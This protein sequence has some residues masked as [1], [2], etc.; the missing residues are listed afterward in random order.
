MGLPRSDSL[1]R[2]LDSGRPEDAVDLLLQAGLVE[3]LPRPGGDLLGF[4]DSA[5]ERLAYYRATLTPGLVWF[6]VLALALRREMPRD[7]LLRVAARWLELMRVEW[8]PPAAPEREERLCTALGHA[9]ERRWILQDAEGRIEPTPEGHFWLGFFAEQI[10]P[11][12]ETYGA[13]FAAARIDG[14]TPRQK[15]IEAAERAL[16][17]QLLL[18]EVR[19]TEAVCPTTIGNALKL[20]LDEGVLVVD[21]NERAAQAL[22]S[23]G[24]DHARLGEL[25]ERVAQSLR[26]R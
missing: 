11:L 5:R 18:G 14:P 22:Y 19:C 8:F 3:R 10:R 2:R 6:S 16:E 15:L 12:L 23:P 1:K 13:L 17:D 7:E 21:G 20:L 25:A 9:L 4:S 26:T 24:P